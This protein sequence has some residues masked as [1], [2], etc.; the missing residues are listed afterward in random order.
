M[1]RTYLVLQSITNQMQSIEL[2]YSDLLGTTISALGFV[3]Y[4][5][6]Y[7]LGNSADHNSSYYL[8]YL[9]NS[10]IVGSDLQI[11]VEENLEWASATQ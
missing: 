9:G 2:E 5:S 8:R 7:P 3:K 1:E 4:Y 11:V 6:C 10:Q